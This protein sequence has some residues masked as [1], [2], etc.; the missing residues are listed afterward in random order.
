VKK[1]LVL[2]ALV[3]ALVVPQVASA[4]F[5]AVQSVKNPV[6]H[7]WNNMLVVCEDDDLFLQFCLPLGLNWFS[8]GPQD[9]VPIFFDGLFLLDGTFLPFLDEDFIVLSDGSIVPLIG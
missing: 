5:I 3:V 1:L 9:F 7:G 2:C 4:Q 8:N 6:H